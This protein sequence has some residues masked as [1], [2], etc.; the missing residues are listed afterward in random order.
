MKA[1]LGAALA[2]IG[3]VGVEAKAV[4]AHFMVGNTGNYTLG[5]WSDDMKLAKAAHIDAFALNMAY[6]DP[7]NGPGLAGA[8]QAAE[9]TGLQLFFSFD[10]AG[11]G[12]WPQQD[13][14][15]L[16]VKYGGRG[17][18]FHHQGQMFVSTFEGPG[19]ADDWH[20]IKA[21]TGCFFMPDW[22]SLGAKAAMQAG[23]GVADGL[24]SWEAW[25]WGKW[26][27]WTY[28]DAS[29]DYYLQGKPYMMPVS[30]WF[31]TN[32]PGYDKNW[33][34]R[35]DR[36]WA[37]RW[38]QASW[39]QPEFVEIISWNDYGESHYI[40]PVRREAL[41]AFGIGQAPFPYGELPHDE[42][43]SILPF[44]IDMYKNNHSTVTTELATAWYRTAPAQL[45]S[46]DGTTAN[47]ASQIQI[48]FAP[49][50]VLEDAIYYAAVLTE[51]PSKVECMIG[52]TVVPGVQ[53]SGPEGN[54]AGLYV[55]SC[56][57]AGHQG[58][59]QIGFSRGG[60]LIM[61][62]L[63]GKYAIEGD[64]AQWAGHNNFNAYVMGSRAPT[65]VHAEAADISDLFCVNGTG[66]PLVE[67][68]VRSSLNLSTPNHLYS[69]TTFSS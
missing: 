69:P 27:K 68:L 1:L 15:D 20:A 39:W 28:S 64:C 56:S 10:Y 35:G 31:Y 30:P 22:S 26:D 9:E 6:D 55:G 4:F 59:V 21:A 63:V 54:D 45:C 19:S 46:F 17:S 33:L 7:S 51:A 61:P 16:L 65:T 53:H 62:E 38:F 42:W 47:T 11:N 29:Y 66:M 12:P 32:L 36:M 50:E 8:F 57:F 3:I 67:D 49:Y 44:V 48:E 37:D 25:A 60:Q 2:A 13:V 14:I 23:G 5:D 58:S 40:G 18:Y 41:E 34:W 43:R 52:G 24:F